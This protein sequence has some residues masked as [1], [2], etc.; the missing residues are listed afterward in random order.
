MQAPIADLLGV[1]MQVD[2]INPREQLPATVIGELLDVSG[3]D[4]IRTK[5]PKLQC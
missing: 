2:L 5:S 4:A 3:Y 1:A